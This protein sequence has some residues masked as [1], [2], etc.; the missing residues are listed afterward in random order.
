M[1]TVPNKIKKLLFASAIVFLSVGVLLAVLTV[2]T[3]IILLANEGAVLKEELDNPYINVDYERWHWV[4]INDWG[5]CLFP[6]EWNAT[7]EDSIVR[8]KDADGNTIAF[9]SVLDAE[10]AFTSKEQFLTE[11]L[12]TE[13]TQTHIEYSREFIPID[14]S[15]SGTISTTGEPEVNYG[16]LQLQKY[17]QPPFLLVFPS[18]TDMDSVELVDLTQAIAYSYSFPDECK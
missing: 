5:S 15:C 7:A 6:E 12:R 2:L 14:M 10:N 8:I 16:F 1:L 3:P 11:I 17:G 4:E 18:H 9:G 13:V